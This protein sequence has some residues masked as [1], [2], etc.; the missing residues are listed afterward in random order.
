M[1]PGISRRPLDLDDVGAHIGQH[2]RRVRA[3]D[4]LREIDDA[5]AVQ[6]GCHRYPFDPGRVK[7]DAILPRPL[8]LVEA[9]GVQ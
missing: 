1:P 8:A 2:H 6:W 3:G 9:A 5:D 7:A 4:V